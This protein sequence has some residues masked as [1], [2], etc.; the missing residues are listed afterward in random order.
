MT[1]TSTP[2]TTTKRALVSTA[3]LEDV[4]LRQRTAFQRDGIP[5]W[6]LRADRLDRLAALLTD[7][8]GQLCDA[9][10]DDFGS[11]PQA[12]SLIGDVA[13]CLV[14]ISDQ[15][16]HLRRWMRDKHP[17]RALRAA[18]IKLAIR[19]D[20]LGV[21]GIAGP[22]NFP[23]QLTLA[24]A[25]AAI[26]AGNRVMV[27]PSSITAN[28]TALLASAAPRY[29]SKDEF[30]VITPDYGP[31]AAFSKL[32]FDAFFFTGSPETGASVAGDCAANL[33]PVTLELGGKN[34]VLV[35]SDANLRRA[36]VRIAQSALVNSGQVCLCPD[37][38]FVPEGVVAD[39]VQ[40][41]LDTWREMFPTVVGNPEYTSLVNDAAYQRVSALIDDA[42]SK[43]ALVLQAAPTGEPLP[44]RASRKI[45]PTVITGL[46]NEMDIEHAE[47]FGPV[48]AVH[49]YRSIDEAIE[50]VNAH[51]CPL[52]MYWYGPE[53][54]RYRRAVARTRT[55]SVNA[56]DFLA[57][58][59]PGLPFG[60][61]GRSGH[62]NYHGE[63]GFKTFA[64]AR[65]VAF[66]NTPLSLAK[67]F[68]PPYSRMPSAIFRAVAHRP[69]AAGARPV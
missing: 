66:T 42:R 24:P 40:T 33:V 23:L 29:F 3:A 5:S 51:S 44:D 39:F 20:P 17:S 16:R 35:D 68:S 30:A 32:K 25:A 21:V 15:K 45:A 11:R 50:Y 27:R 48:L 62:G 7:N 10:E 60:G 19:R 47:T 46:H 28:T 34:P 55:G 61:V 63:Y 13:A 67:L 14:E 18:G 41:V 64:H 2:G 58:M 54:Q 43:G 65:A 49:P 1:A 37:Y 36:A 69:R 22:W 6:T 56:N 57:N 12:L 59:L 26:A 53:N 31:G 9:L 8:A 4:L 52:T 38:A